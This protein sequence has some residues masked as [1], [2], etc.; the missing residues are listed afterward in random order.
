LLILDVSF[1]CE[2]GFYLERTCSLHDDKVLDDLR[3]IF[4]SNY[5]ATLQWYVSSRKVMLIKFNASNDQKRKGLSFY[6]PRDTIN[7]GLAKINTLFKFRDKNFIA[8]E[9]IKKS[10]ISKI[11]LK[12]RH[13]SKLKTF[14]LALPI[15]FQHDFFS[16][17]KNEVERGRKIPFSIGIRFSPKSVLLHS[18]CQKDCL[19]IGVRTSD[20]FWLNWFKEFSIKYS[21]LFHAGKFT[22]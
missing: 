1:H 8:S 5:S 6:L 11:I 10:M 17:I 4:E 2:N 15:E 19:W 12:F 9:L 18:P 3:K 14:E 21:A 13:F 20:P 22:P 16:E 7:A